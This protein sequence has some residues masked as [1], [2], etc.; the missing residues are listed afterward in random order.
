MKDNEIRQIQGRYSWKDP[1][2]SLY[3]QELEPT[4]ARDILKEVSEVLVERG[5]TR[6][7]DDGEQSM[8]KIVN[9]FNALTDL[10][11]TTE[12]GWL[13][14]LCL[15]LGRMQYGYDRDSYV[16][17]VGYAALLAEEGIQME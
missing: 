15:K 6:E 2:E 8:C 9:T 12:Q 11:L 16:D 13:F 14:M 7:S 5:K 17:L 1:A 3:P 4:T 10:G